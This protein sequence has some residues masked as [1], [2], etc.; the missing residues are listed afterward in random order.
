MNNKSDEDSD[1]QDEEI[2]KYK[3]QWKE[4]ANKFLYPE[5]QLLDQLNKLLLRERQMLGEIDRMVKE[6]RQQMLVEI[7]RIMEE[8]RR[9]MLKEIDRMVEEPRRKMLEEIDR[10]VK[11][12]RRQLLEQIKRIIDSP[13][14]WQGEVTALLE[15]RRHFQKQ[16]EML[17]QPD[18]RWKE[19]LGTYLTNLA[20]QNIVVDSSGAL[21]INGVSFDS[22]D[23][24]SELVLLDHELETR[25][26]FSQLIIHLFA[27]LHK[28][29]KPVADF[30]RVAIISYII[31]VFANLTT[32]IYEQMLA[33][34]SDSGKR[35]TAKRIKKDALKIYSIDQ[36][37]SYKFVIATKLHVRM[38]GSTKSKIVDTLPFGKVVKVL[39]KNKKWVSIEYVSEDAGVVQ[40]GWVFARYLTKFKK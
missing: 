15:Q 28:L 22:S 19:L 29:R 9:Q 23:V 20:P 40:R 37:K 3:P 7:D 5:Q 35:D 12:P 34:Y 6:P 8:P 14:A 2:V 33:K 30:L 16:I 21:V 27:Y 25:A 1:R 10:I 38:S 26:T 18:F 17:F 39:K 13:R 31:S 4:E 32:P 24:A 11:E 36:L